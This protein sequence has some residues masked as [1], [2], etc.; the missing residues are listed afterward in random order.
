MKEVSR[1]EKLKLVYDSSLQRAAQELITRMVTTGT[2]YSGGRVVFD[3]A[4]VLQQ[5][6]SSTAMLGT[7]PCEPVVAA[8]KE[9]LKQVVEVLDNNYPDEI[10]A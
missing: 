10:Q 2:S 6:E 9:I 7:V 8:A 3:E 5:A 1:E 4:A